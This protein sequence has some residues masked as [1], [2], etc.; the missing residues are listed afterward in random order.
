MLSQA[1]VRTCAGRC[2]AGTKRRTLL[3]VSGAA[4]IDGRSRSD[5]IV[6][7]A[8]RAAWRYGAHQTRRYAS[9]TSIM[10]ILTLCGCRN[11]T[12]R[13]V[14][15]TRARPEKTSPSSTARHHWRLHGSSSHR[16]MMHAARTVSLMPTAQS[17]LVHS[18]HQHHQTSSYIGAAESRVSSSSSSRLI[19]S[20]VEILE[21]LC[22]CIGRAPY[23][24]Q[25]RRCLCGASDAQLLRRV[26]GCPVEARHSAGLVARLVARHALNIGGLVDTV[27][28]G[29]LLECGP[30]LDLLAGAACGRE[31]ARTHMH[32]CAQCRAEGT[33]GV[34]MR[35]RAHS[36]RK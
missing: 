29:C 33:R 32:A 20:L 27:T 31:R 1:R 18:H 25:P 30:D 5:S 21:N 17:H 8:A 14:S 10:G 28:N 4:M 3:S 16:M 24:R 7:P 12:V 23:S 9:Q 15:D 6:D 2:T 26:G 35:E 22:A 13:R 36:L 11:H 34:I 19:Y